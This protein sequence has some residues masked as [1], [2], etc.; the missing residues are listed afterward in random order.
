ME[1]V[2]RCHREQ[3]IVRER[4]AERRVRLRDRR[5]EEATITPARAATEAIELALVAPSFVFDLESN[6]RVPPPKRSSWRWWSANTTSTRPSPG[7]QQ[8][9]PGLPP[10]MGVQLPKLRTSQPPAQALLDH[11]SASS[12]DDSVTTMAVEPPYGVPTDTDGKDHSGGARV[13]ER[14]ARALQ[15]GCSPS[16]G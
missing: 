4:A 14:G 1:P 13:G 16:T 11:T 15:K 3:A 5:L 12:T 2:R 10:S 8:S 6:M 9:A 7:G